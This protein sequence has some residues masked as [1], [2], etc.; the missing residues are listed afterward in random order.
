M[1]P[2]VHFNASC[3]AFVTAA[4]HVC[5]VLTASPHAAYMLG[6]FHDHIKYPCH[7]VCPLSWPCE[8]EVHSS[9]Q[10]QQHSTLTLAAVS[11]LCICVWKDAP[12]YPSLCASCAAFGTLPITAGMPTVSGGW[13]VASMMLRYVC[14]TAL[15]RE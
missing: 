1:Q 11:D 2:L 5:S 15:I 12:G 3:P 6:K 10:V 7:C 4:K 13:T 8:M 14:L 9:Q